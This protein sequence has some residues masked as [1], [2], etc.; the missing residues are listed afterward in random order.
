MISD[1]RGR[2]PSRQSRQSSFS[3]SI[4]I[5]SKQSSQRIDPRYSAQLIHLSSIRK[6]NFAPLL[7]RRRLA[8]NR[9]NLSATIDVSPNNSR[10]SSTGGRLGLT[11]SIPSLSSVDATPMATSAS[12]A[13]SVIVVDNHHCCLSRRSRPSSAA[14][15]RSLAASVRSS[16]RRRNSEEEIAVAYDRSISAMMGRTQ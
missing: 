2:R 13:P 4:D 5:S 6:T 11:F 15:S 9:R 14:Q 12:P 8:R 7:R 16:L 1:G 3:I 10:F